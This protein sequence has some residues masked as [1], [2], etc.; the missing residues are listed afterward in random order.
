MFQSIWVN[1]LIAGIISACSMPLGSL[2]ALVWTPKKR[3]LAFLMAFGAGALL[4]ALVIDLVGSARDKGHLLELIIGSILGS[5]FL[6]FVNRT[7]N[8]AGG[9][10]RK[11]STTLAHLT[12]K[13]QSCYGVLNG[14]F[15][16]NKTEV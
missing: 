6:I 4:A 15:C 12:D 9:F 14:N 5:L 8:N 3:I 2:T 13:Q 7:V 1:A 11:A 10:L 16:Q